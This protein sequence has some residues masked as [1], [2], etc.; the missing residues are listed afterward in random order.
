[1]CGILGVLYHGSLE[2]PDQERLE[3][4]ARLLHHRGPDHQAI[5]AGEGIGLVHTR[6]ALLDL[7]PRSNQ[8]QSYLCLISQPSNA[9]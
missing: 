4:S 6:L 5:F 2:T 9:L 7:N 1:M 8:T 3:A